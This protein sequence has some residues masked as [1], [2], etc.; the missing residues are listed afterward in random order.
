MRMKTIKRKMRLAMLP[1]EAVWELFIRMKGIPDKTMEHVGEHAV[2][3]S[4]AVAIVQN[5]YSYLYVGDY[6]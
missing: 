5:K 3:W 4:D 2:V 6:P 1:E